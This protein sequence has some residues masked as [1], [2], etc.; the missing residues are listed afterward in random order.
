[1]ASLISGTFSSR[2]RAA[3]ASKN[4]SGTTWLDPGDLQHLA[5]VE[6]TKPAMRHFRDAEP[7]DAQQGRADRPAG[8]EHL[9]LAAA[10]RAVK[11]NDRE[12]GEQQDRAEKAR[13]AAPRRSAARTGGADAAT[14][15]AGPA[16]PARGATTTD[17]DPA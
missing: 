4:G 7:S 3:A 9:V 10:H 15:A 14:R 2:S 17:P 5:V 1:M 16:D 6:V 13:Q 8:D 12:E 11:P